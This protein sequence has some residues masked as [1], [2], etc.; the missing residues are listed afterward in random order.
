MTFAYEVLTDPEKR[1]MYD[2]YG[3]EAVREGGNQGGGPSFGFGGGSLFDLFDSGGLF[4]GGGR[5]RKR[6]TDDLGVPLE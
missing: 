5:R 1:Q 4:G 2:N 3:I 6:R